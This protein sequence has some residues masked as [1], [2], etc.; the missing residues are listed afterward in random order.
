MPS[1]FSVFMLRLVFLVRRTISVLGRLFLLF[2]L[3]LLL[4][5]LVF[6]AAA[7]SRHD[8]IAQASHGDRYQHGHDVSASGRLGL[9]LGFDGRGWS[10]SGTVR[11]QEDRL[12]VRVLE[13]L[14]PSLCFQLGEFKRGLKFKR[15]IVSLRDKIRTTKS[16]QLPKQNK[17]P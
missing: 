15:V 6:G 17:K 9:E 12:P 1:P 14:V 5:F 16:D 3:L 8:V 11:L 10:G 2:A 7:A 13:R 4:V